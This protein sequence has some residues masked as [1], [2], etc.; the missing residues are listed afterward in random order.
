MPLPPSAGGNLKKLPPIMLDVGGVPLQTVNCYKYLGVTLDGQLN[1]AKHVNRTISNV[2]LK[3]KQFRR[4]RPFLTT[5]AAIMVYKNMLLPMIEYGDVFVKGATLELKC[6][7]E[8]G[9]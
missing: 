4:M 5:T 8:Q 2:A 6:P 1:F 7:T 3:L 9:P